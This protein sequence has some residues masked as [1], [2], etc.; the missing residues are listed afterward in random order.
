M[1]RYLVFLVGCSLIASACSD[2]VDNGEL[3]LTSPSPGQA[4]IAGTEVTIT[5]TG[6]GA[7]EQVAIYLEDDQGTRLDISSATEN[8]GEYVWSVPLLAD[9]RMRPANLVV[10]LPGVDMAQSR[11]PTDIRN[12]TTASIEV[13][14]FAAFRWNQVEAQLEYYWID[15][16]TGE[17]AVIQQLGDYY[18][19]TH[20]SVID[21]VNE[22]IFVF[23]VGNND[24]AQ[25]LLVIDTIMGTVTNSPM[26][27]GPGALR[28]TSPVLRSDGTLLAFRTTSDFSGVEM[29]AVSDMGAVAPL[30]RVG[31]LENWD[32]DSTADVANDKIYV[33]GAPPSTG[34]YEGRIY[35]MDSMSG[36]LDND[37]GLLSDGQTIGIPHGLVHYQGSELRA[38]LN[39]G[40]ET[41]ELIAID[42]SD[43][44]T[45]VVNTFEDMDHWDGT[46]RFN[47][48][49]GE[50]LMFGFEAE[51]AY[52][53]A[54]AASD[55]QYLY[56]RA[57][58]DPTDALLVYT[59]FSP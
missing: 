5:W 25:Y 29:V 23:V 43:G 36:T 35:I 32:Y 12:L 48:T 8:D 10:A 59:N 18:T 13:G 14:S 54:F 45:S 34:D 21:R 2:P 41:F 38:V 51:N 1:I 49:T 58:T 47:A 4:L 16:A 56:R 22:R 55:G 40:A 20:W 11:R 17:S 31:D 15:P 46:A 6:A 53:Y 33:S 52:L 44:A 30:D 57:I 39:S 7:E 37:V 19:E 27:A 28:L 42:S 26:V 24:D 3:A 50:F 9:F